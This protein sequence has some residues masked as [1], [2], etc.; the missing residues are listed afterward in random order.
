MNFEYAVL[1]IVHDLIRVIAYTIGNR[2]SDN[3]YNLFLESSDENSM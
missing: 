1:Q 3:Y 2:K